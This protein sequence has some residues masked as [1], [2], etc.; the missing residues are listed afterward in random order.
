MTRKEK[1]KALQEISEGKLSIEDLEPP[2]VYFFTKNSN[3]PGVYEMNG[4]E[5]SET[6]YQEVKKKVERKNNGSIIWNEGKEY[7]DQD[8]IITIVFPEGV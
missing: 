1:L 8:A 7:R 3:K 5:Y 6:E 4:K 2:Q